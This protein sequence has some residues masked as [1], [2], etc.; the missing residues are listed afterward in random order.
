MLAICPEGFEESDVPNGL[1]LAAYTDSDGAE[2]LTAAF[3]SVAS[4]PVEADWA[5]RWRDFHRPVQAGPFWVGPPWEPPP[6]R[7]RAIVIDPGRAFGTGAHP[8]TRLCLE[9]LPALP[10]GTLV[11]VGCGSGVLAIAGAKLGFGA[12]VALDSDPA[13]V[14]ATRANARRNSVALDVRLLDAL[15]DPLPAAD[16]V[17]ANVTLEHLRALAPRL[18]TRWLVASGYPETDA[19]ALP[20]FERRGRRTAEG[21]AAELFERLA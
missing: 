19:L 10:R 17:I 9:F 13:A 4:A 8:T 21:W 11:D 2:R 16:A 15:A 12:V 18:L 1:E 20:A 5:D 7:A 3:G 6:D 14:E